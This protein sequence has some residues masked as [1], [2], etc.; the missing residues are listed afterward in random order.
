[1]KK[2]IIFL[3]LLNFVYSN[4]IIKLNGYRDNKANF[5]YYTS[6]LSKVLEE[7]RTEYGDYKLE[8]SK[9]PMTQG[10]VIEEL[11]LGENISIDWLGTNKEREKELLPIRIPLLGGLLGYRVPVIRRSDIGYF[12]DI[13]TKKELGILTGIQGSQWPDLDILLSNSLNSIG[14][15]DFKNMYP[16]LLG[17]RADYFPRE[18]TN[19][20]NEVYEHGQGALIV[21]DK[22]IIHYTFPL[23][24]FVNKNNTRLAERIEKGLMKMVE[25]GKLR[26]HIMTHPNTRDVFPLD[27]YKNSR[28]IELVNP[29]LPEKTPLEDK[30]L[31]IK[32]DNE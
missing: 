4:D 28:I 9:I 1:M 21:Y 14:V 12:D 32:F 10:R 11:K 18:I 3:F 5:D 16:M 13:Y 8:Y 24:F 2:I 15:S 6:L 31:W 23:Y 29:D 17:H 26:E 20:Y 22:L 27:K 25:E 7:T 30:R 19:A